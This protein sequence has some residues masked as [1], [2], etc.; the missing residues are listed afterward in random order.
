MTVSNLNISTAMSTAV[1]AVLNNASLTDFTITITITNTL[2]QNYSFTP[3]W[4]DSITINQ[5]FAD[6]FADEVFLE[7]GAAPQDYMTMFA[8]TQGLSVSLIFTYMNPQS[9]MLAFSPAPVSRTYKVM[10]MHPLDLSKKFTT[11]QMMPTETM[12]LVEQHVSARVPVKLWLIENTAYSLRQQSYWGTK[13][14]STLSSVIG[15]ISSQFGIKQLYLVPPDNKT[16]WQHVIIP[17]SQKFDKVFDFLHFQYGIYMKGVEWYY[18]NGILYIWP[19]YENNPIIKYT[20]NIY[21]VAGGDYAG[22]ISFHSS[23]LSSNNLSLISTTQ[24]KTTDLSRPAAE[25]VG[26]S[27]SFMRAATLIDGT[28]T[29]NAQGTFINNNNALT[30]GTVIDRAA[31]QNASNPQYTKTTDN[32]FYESSK[33][34]KWNAATIECGWKKAV[35]FLLYPGHNVK[36]HF[37][38]QGIFTS[39]QGILEAVFYTF[40]R[41]QKIGPNYTYSGEAK[42]HL[43][44]DSDVT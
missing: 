18:S 28:T 15:Y 21:N 8:N 19:P 6:A 12:P 30:V 11:G 9:G 4:I 20:A 38:K 26:T 43:R 40:T 23:D 34:A 14:N 3:D 13:Y 17:P 16:Q 7:F 41:S 5:N 24:V 44:A 32:I 22:L 2:N 39:Q 33:L 10:M 36:Y 1:E 42:L 31:S 37:D 35:P 25:D 27:F 29:T